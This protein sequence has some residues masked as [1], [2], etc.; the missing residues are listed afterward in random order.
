[1]DVQELPMWTVTITY[2]D[3]TAKVIFAL[4]LD[5]FHHKMVPYIH[6]EADSPMHSVLIH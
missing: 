5:D 1:M 6:N 4:N 3:G 2:R